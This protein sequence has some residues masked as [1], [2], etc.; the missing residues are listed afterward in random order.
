MSFFSL[1]QIHYPI[2]PYVFDNLV[3]RKPLHTP[4]G[5]PDRDFLIGHARRGIERV[6][7]LR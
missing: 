6:P 4:S 3:G 1:T 2:V 7:G 5:I